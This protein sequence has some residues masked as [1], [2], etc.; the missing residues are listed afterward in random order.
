MKTPI[1]KTK[2][3]DLTDSIRSY[4]EEKTALIFDLLPDKDVSAAQVRVEVG[5]PSLRHNTGAVYRA[6]INLSVGRRL[7][8]A[9]TVHEDLYAAINETRD[10]IERQIRKHKTKLVAQRRPK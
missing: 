4:V 5:R 9:E 10:E 3:I 6:E 7:Y 1:I 2:N 8:R